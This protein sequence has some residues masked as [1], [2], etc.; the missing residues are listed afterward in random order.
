M[1]KKFNYNCKE[2]IIYDKS[3]Y[4]KKFKLVM[5][6]L[7]NAV[8]DDSIYLSNFELRDAYRLRFYEKNK[9]KNHNIISLIIEYPIKYDLE[10][11]INYLI[12]NYEDI[13]SD[14]LLQ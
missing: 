3:T 14:I 10:E 4:K 12:N 7:K 13:R 2:L 8:Y 6:N 5:N 1:T 9:K 11:D